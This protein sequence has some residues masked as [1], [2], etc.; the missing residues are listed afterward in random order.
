[1]KLDTAETVKVVAVSRSVMIRVRDVV[2]P[3]GVVKSPVTVAL[4][5][6]FLI[7]MTN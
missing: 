7:V 1:V 5:K 2:C 6:W 3:D 4:V